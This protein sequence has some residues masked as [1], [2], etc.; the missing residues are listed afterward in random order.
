MNRL[1][2]GGFA[3]VTL[4]VVLAD[5][6]YAVQEPAPRTL[7]AHAI[8]SALAV[9]AT[10]G[11]YRRSDPDRR[12]AWA[13]YGAPMVATLAVYASWML[14]YAMSSPV[15]AMVVTGAFHVA[16]IV[17][18]AIARPSRGSREG[19]MAWLLDVG[20]L[21]AAA[22]TLLLSVLARHAGY[23]AYANTRFLEDVRSLGAALATCSVTFLGV[24]SLSDDGTSEPGL[25]T[26]LASVAFIAAGDLLLELSP[27]W[28]RGAGAWWGV[29][30]FGLVVGGLRAG[31]AVPPLPGTRRR[32]S[33]S[34]VPFIAIGVLLLALIADAMSAAAP[35]A[36]VLAIGAGV[37]VTLVLVRQWLAL[38]ENAAL[39]RARLEA[40][41]GR[42]DADRRRRESERLDALGRMAQ[43]VAHDFNSLLTGIIQNADLAL[44]DLHDPALAAESLRHVKQSA[45]TAGTITRH[46][47]AFARTGT[48]ILHP[49]DARAAVG[50]H[51]ETLRAGVPEGVRMDVRLCDGP[52]MVRSASGFTEQVLGNLVRNAVDA[53]PDGGTL[54]VLL[55]RDDDTAVLTVEDT[56]HGM[57]EATRAR[58][59][60]PFFSTKGVRG[61]GLGLPSSWGLVR[62]CGGDMGV[63][64]ALGHGTRFRVTWPLTAA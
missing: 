51:L 6:A 18:T 54:T 36:H 57:D 29:G 14:G 7:C 45:V 48:V 53:M 38:R 64:T 10:A 59:F 58:L 4:G 63:E 21:I 16:A 34:L 17:G 22:A 11:A 49:V 52:L 19:G 5:P 61:T 50:R 9:V 55:E 33:P 42:L 27:G 39:M 8:L 30:A 37:T 40:E 47:L 32:N 41:R 24:R 62:Q 3:A 60:E 26:A 23:G 28:S 56:G 35:D 15:L 20:L 2:L 1:V 43:G 13:W 25:S 31:P 46:L 12:W 44:D